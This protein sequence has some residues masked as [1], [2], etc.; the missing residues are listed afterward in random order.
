[1][2]LAL[3]LIDPGEPA[4]EDPVPV[5]ST[6]ARVDQRG[7][8]R[9]IPAVPVRPGGPYV[10]LTLRTVSP[11]VV[12][13][14]PYPF[15]EPEFELAVSARRIEDRRYASAEEASAAY[16]GAEEDRISINIGPA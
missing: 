13:L 15:H 7:G 16:R 14:D 5:P 3:G 8:A 9:S 11:G 2:S 4:T 1:M 10:E 12:T 6:L